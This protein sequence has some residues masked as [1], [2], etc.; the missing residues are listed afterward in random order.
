MKLQLKRVLRHRLATSHR[1]VFPAASMDR[2]TR[3]VA[4]SEQHHSGQIRICIETR[5]PQ[6]DLVSKQDTAALVR[7]RALYQFSHLHVW[8]TEH[9]NGVLI[10]LLIAER[11]IEIVADRGLNSRVDAEVWK[12]LVTQL[13]EDFHQGRF[14]QGLEATVVAVGGLL[15]QHFPLQPGQVTTNELP[16]EPVVQ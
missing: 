5:L 9:N 16:N 7:Q 2:L 1:S 14:E 11:A 13:G 8:D 6:L 10:Y 3:L 15:Q 4:E 12:M